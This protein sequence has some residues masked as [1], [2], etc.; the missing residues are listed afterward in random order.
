LASACATEPSDIVGCA[1]YYQYTQ[2]TLDRAADEYDALKPG[3]LRVLVDDYGS[4]RAE[5]RE[6]KCDQG[7]SVRLSPGTEPERRTK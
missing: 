2:P 3:G 1:T 7:T 5:Q 6:M 4:I